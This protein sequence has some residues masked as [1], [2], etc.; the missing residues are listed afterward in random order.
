[1]NVLI[2]E[3]NLTDRKI[4]Q[5]IFSEYGKCDVA[6]G[7][8]EA[9]DAYKR[10]WMTCKP[11]DLICMDIIMPGVNGLQALKRIREIEKE[12]SIDD[13]E[14][15]KVIMITAVD[16]PKIVFKASNL[17]GVNSYIVKPIHKKKLLDEVKKMGLIS[18]SIFS[19]RQ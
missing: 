10:S 12:Y 1:M 19:G 18:D 15:V 9:I 13:N 2:V 17:F 3:D 11:Y 16:D 4:L 6:T 5:N 7:G 8:A 14:G